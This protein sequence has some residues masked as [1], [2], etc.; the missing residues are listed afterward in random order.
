MIVKIK[1]GELLIRK[2]R[3]ER[4]VIKMYVDDRLE[5]VGISSH[6]KDRLIEKFWG[7]TIDKLELLLQSSGI[8]SFNPSKDK[9]P[10]NLSIQTIN[11]IK[12]K[13]IKYGRETRFYLI[14][15]DDIVLC[16]CPNKYKNIY[17][18]EWCLTTIWRSK[19]GIYNYK[20]VQREREFIKV[21]GRRI[22]SV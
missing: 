15:S 2:I 21:N 4:N 20:N 13:H 18:N 7:L 5:N 1:D 22:Y 6:F 10:D 14:P 16:I 8:I 3:N 9:I 11:N 12:S 17:S 19:V